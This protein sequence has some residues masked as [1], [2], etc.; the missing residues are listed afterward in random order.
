MHRVPEH[1]RLC[2]L[3]DESL[4]P[5]TYLQ[6]EIAVRLTKE[7]E[8]DLL[9]VLSQ[10]FKQIQLWTHEFDSDS[11][12]GMGVEVPACDSKCSGG[13]N[14]QCDDHEIHICLTK[15]IGDL[16]HLLPVE[17]LH[18]QHLASNVLVAISDYLVAA[19]S[20]WDEYMQSLCA[21]LELAISNA[22][23]H[24]LE[25]PSTKA[26]VSSNDS[27]SVTFALKPSLKN[28]NWSSVACV[29]RVLRNVLKHL[30][31]DTDDQLLEVYLD[32]IS[33]CLSNVPWESMDEVHVGQS[34]EALGVSRGFFFYTKAGQLESRNVF[35]GTVVQFF[36]SLVNQSGWMEA[37][38][39]PLNKH[40]VIHEIS[41]LI[42]RIS[43]WCLGDGHRNNTCMSDY[44]KHKILMLMIRLSFQIHLE[45][46]L[47]V[48]WLRLIHK[49]F[50]D[51]LLLPM[52]EQ[53]S[54]QHSLEGS[55]FLASFSDPRICD[56]TSSHLQRLVVFLFLRCSLSLVSLKDR[57]AKQCGCAHLKSCKNSGLNSDPECCREKTGLS[58]LSVWLQGHLS[59]EMFV[60]CES[61]S[62]R[63]ISFS[64]SF[65][66]LF[67]HEDDILFEVLLQLFCVPFCHKQKVCEARRAFQEMKDDMH[68]HV[69]NLFNPL[70]LFHL[71]LAELHYD[72]QVLLDYLISKDTGARS[73]E[74]L[75][76]SL[77]VICDSWNVFVEF[78][79]EGK[80]MYMREIHKSSG[81]KRKVLA[82]GSD[83]LGHLTPLSMKS[84]GIPV[85]LGKQY[86]KDFM[87]ANRI[88]F[89]NAK[90]CLLSLKK[91]VQSLH[92]KKLFPYN[93]KVLLQRLTRFEDL[94]LKREN[95]FQGK[96][97]L[98]S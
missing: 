23:L 1:S 44:F 61:Y 73:A 16:I 32:S 12:N 66:K 57:T 82:D 31:Q 71:F 48:S 79:V 34:G 40:P 55:P 42:P 72:H 59:A 63:C 96:A 68:F 37:A 20:H 94:C 46:C 47:L 27:S 50:E 39:G 6:E 65:L 51:L 64:L 26:L 81:K 43:A 84:K 62:E 69:S 36:C 14:L 5:F 86:Q 15:I 75:L 49:Y 67:I 87:W 56:T 95:I 10:V 98:I 8:K 92:Q 90:D 89:E 58:E 30:K 9:I 35:Y 38:G 11:D 21:C 85:S 22:L 4:R 91:S 93:P 53:G 52:T 78:S 76:R 25:C 83:F 7:T 80:V 74:Y 2:R 18:V 97:E 45:C 19:E 24:S 77:R 60:G 3:I 33:S 17:S 28:A 54:D 70:H 88:P 13:M 41:N 29:I